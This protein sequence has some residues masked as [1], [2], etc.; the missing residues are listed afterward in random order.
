MPRL[1]CTDHHNGVVTMQSSLLARLGVVHAFTT[2]LGGV[3][4]GPFRSLNLAGRRSTGGED[5][6]EALDENRRRLFVALGGDGG[7][8]IDAPR[9]SRQFAVAYVNQVHGAEVAIV[10]G[11]PVHRDSGH[12]PT[13]D[14]LATIQPGIALMIRV[15]DCVP[16][17]L[18]CERPRAI[19][20]IH[21]GWRGIVA[22]V[23]PA[24][25]QR[26]VAE[27]GVD[28]ANCVAAI[29]PCIGV[30][31]FEVG[32]EVAAALTECDAHGGLE[33]A[34]V[35]SPRWPKPHTDLFAAARIQLQRAGLASDHIDG[36][37]LC[38]HANADL[39]FSHRRDAGRSGRMA[40]VIALT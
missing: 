10:D 26:I 16:I 20:A 40:A 4:V 19:A 28:R 31:A 27:F 22:G 25:M 14:V 1:T 18:A 6:P 3:S 21:A 36:E 24:A 39:F 13:A 33:S 11:A 8:T 17:L 7:E 29:G 23:I 35:R 30:D 2:R 12:A 5:L 15:A 32:E 37:P 38:T 34:V 9:A